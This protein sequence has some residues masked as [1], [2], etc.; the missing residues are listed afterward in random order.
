MKFPHC[1]QTGWNSSNFFKIFDNICHRNLLWNTGSFMYALRNNSYL[2]FYQRIN[3][4]LHSFISTFVQHLLELRY[5]SSSIFLICFYLIFQDGQVFCSTKTPCLSNEES[6]TS[7][8]LDPDLT[9]SS[10]QSSTDTNNWQNYWRY[11]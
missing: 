8:N 11:F 10:H 5:C 2:H 4:T 7:Q 3:L 9:E 6:R 1:A